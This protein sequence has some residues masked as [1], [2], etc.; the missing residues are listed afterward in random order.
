MSPFYKNYKIANKNYDIIFFLL[1]KCHCCIEFKKH[2]TTIADHLLF[3]SKVG[4]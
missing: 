3:L 1:L 4:R 2:V